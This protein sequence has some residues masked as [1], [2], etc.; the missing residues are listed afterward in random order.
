MSSTSISKDQVIAF[1]D[2]LKNRPSL[3]SPD[4]ENYRDRNERHDLLT[5]IAVSFAM[6]KAE[7]ENKIMY[8][9]VKIHSK[10][11]C[12]NTVGQQINKFENN[13]EDFEE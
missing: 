7:V 4:H 12:L 10:T 1:I 9:N 13:S 11:V 2:M 6:W 8:V 5:E 3:W